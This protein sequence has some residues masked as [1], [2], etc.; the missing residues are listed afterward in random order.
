MTILNIISILKNY[1][2]NINN[3]ITKSIH[4]IFALENK[5]FKTLNVYIIFQ[6]GIGAETINYRLKDNVKFV[7]PY[8]SLIKYI[9]T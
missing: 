4:S 1:I 3:N 7:K 2:Y 8:R 5:T 9:G 6:I